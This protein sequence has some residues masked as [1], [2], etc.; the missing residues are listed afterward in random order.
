MPSPI[1]TPTTANE[2]RTRERR[3][4]VRSAAEAVEQ[5]RAALGP[6]ARVVSVR[7]VKGSGLQRFLAAP[8]LEI[9]ARAGPPPA[10]QPEEPAPEPMLP[11]PIPIPLT[12]RE[13]PSGASLNCRKFLEKAGLPPPLLARLDGAQEWRQIGEMDLRQGLPL[14]VRSLRH[15]LKALSGNPLPSTVA[16]LGGPGSGKTTALCKLLAK[17]VFISGRAPQVLRLEVDKPHLDDGLLLYC[18]VLGVHC[19]RSPKE[20]DRAEGQTLYVDIPGY[21][22]REP[23]EQKRIQASLDELAIEGRVLVLN[24]AYEEAVLRRFTESGQRM[25]ARHQILTHLDELESV[26][27]LW[28]YLLDPDCSLLFFS[29]G[30]NIAGD[31]VDDPFGYLLDRTFPV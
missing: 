2:A 16:F 10:P 15:R 25:G 8:R 11:E 22:L 26:G 18:E 3:F 23:S 7:Q 1:P 6:Q 9:I 28:Q 17:D 14:V 21:S 31:R 19:A 12:E 30:Q 13:S 24:A 4:I 27:K 5:V 29:D 20:V